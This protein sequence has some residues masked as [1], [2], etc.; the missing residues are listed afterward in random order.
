MSEVKLKK[1]VTLKRKGESSSPQPAKKSKSWLWILLSTFLVAAL[2]LF[3][4]TQESSSKIEN[5]TTSAKDSTTQIVNTA[6]TGTIDTETVAPDETSTPDVTSSASTNEE[7][8]A[9]E[10][11]PSEKP[12]QTSQ[13]TV[14][15]EVMPAKDNP[16]ISGSLEEKVRRTIR[17]DFGNGIDRR[18]ALGTEYATIQQLVN[19][20]YQEEKFD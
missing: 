16:V 20:A 3:F 8:A 1:K 7:I 14:S 6:P 5:P 13:Q 15:E 19:K 10:K 11:A 17:G 4:V 12:A 9:P 2:V 18:R